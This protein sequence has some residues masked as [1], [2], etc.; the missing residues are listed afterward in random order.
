MATN[1]ALNP[2]RSHSRKANEIQYTSINANGVLLDKVFSLRYKSYLSDG[3]LEPNPTEKFMDNLDSHENC[4]SFLTYANHHIVGSMRSCMYT[5]QNPI[6]LPVLE[7]FYGEIRDYVGLEKPLIEINRFVVDPDFQK[8]SGFKTLFNLFNK[9]VDHIIE[10]KVECVL[11]SVREEHLSFYKRL[12]FETVTNAE[13]KPYP[14]LKFK[15]ILIVHWDVQKFK[16]II[17]SKLQ[18]KQKGAHH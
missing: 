11:A 18:P 16:D 4:Q 2:E 7:Q 8:R 17:M 15:S 10:N 13:A 3:F 9:S 14:L 6:K 12:G 1:L 5:P